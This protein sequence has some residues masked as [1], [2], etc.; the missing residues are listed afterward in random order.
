M[1][2]KKLNHNKIFDY[3][4]Q[5]TNWIKFRWVLLESVFSGFFHLGLSPW[6]Q[7]KTTA[8]QSQT[9]NAKTLINNNS[10]LSNLPQTA[11]KSHKHTHVHTNLHNTVKCTK[12]KNVTSLFYTS[13]THTRL[14]ILPKKHKVW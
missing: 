6:S 3:D 14:Q 2:Q 11:E 8:K 7:P 1:F 5:E 9:N 12:A 10:K 4:E 13:G